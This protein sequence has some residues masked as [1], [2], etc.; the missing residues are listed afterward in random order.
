[1]SGKL[2]MI[3][4]VTNLKTTLLI[5]LKDFLEVMVLLCKTDLILNQTK[6]FI[7]HNI[8]EDILFSIFSLIEFVQHLIEVFDP[9]A[10]MEQI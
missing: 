2:P 1:M 3:L 5:L 10:G 6:L 8:K 7:L 4:G 9:V